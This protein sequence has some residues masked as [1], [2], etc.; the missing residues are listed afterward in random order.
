MLRN[1]LADMFRRLQVAHPIMMTEGD[2]ANIFIKMVLVRITVVIRFVGA[3][4]MLVPLTGKHALPANRLKAA[5]NAANTGKK[6]DKAKS[7]MWM[8]RRRPRQQVVQ[9]SQLTVAE[10]M[11]RFIGNHSLE[12]GRTP[13]VLANTIQMSN[14]RFH[15]IYFKQ[16]SQNHLC[17][18]LVIIC[19]RVHGTCY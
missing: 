13:A 16:L 12:D 1:M 18:G 7:I 19:H 3:H 8:M 10:A 6:I 9:M 17:G 15:V 14:Q 5:T 11:P 4:R 2:I